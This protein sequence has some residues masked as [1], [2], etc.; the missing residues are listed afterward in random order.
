MIGIVNEKME[1][2]ADQKRTG[3]RDCKQ[4]ETQWM[5]PYHETDTDHRTDEYRSEDEHVLPHRQPDR[6][7]RMSCSVTDGDDQVEAENREKDYV[8]VHSCPP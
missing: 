7:Q 3:H 4:R 5:S 6:N 1:D 2:P 8:P